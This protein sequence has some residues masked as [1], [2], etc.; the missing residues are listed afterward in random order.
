MCKHCTDPACP[1]RAP[2]CEH[3]P[4]NETAIRT[5]IMLGATYYQDQRGLWHIEGL[6]VSSSNKTM[7]AWMYLLTF[8]LGV[9]GDAN[10]I[11]IVHMKP[12]KDRGCEAY[13]RIGLI[14]REV[15]NGEND[16][17]SG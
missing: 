13:R 1:A 15:N 12:D 7:P 4:R 10:P 14:L 8:G 3:S 16:N 6:Q 11:P 2:D 5:A 9:D 17:G